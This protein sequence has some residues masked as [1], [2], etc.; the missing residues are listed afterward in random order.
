M[1]TLDVLQPDPKAGPLGS[2]KP[3]RCA[4]DGCKEDGRWKGYCLKHYTLASRQEQTQRKE[5]PMTEQNSAAT[6]EKKPEQTAKKKPIPQEKFEEV[7]NRA[8]T[9]QEAA[10]ELRVSSGAIATRCKTHGIPTPAQ[11][12]GK[13][14]AKKKT[15]PKKKAPATA[16]V[17]LQAKNPPMLP[18][19]MGPVVALE[20]EACALQKIVTALQEL[21]PLAQGRVLAH[22]TAAINS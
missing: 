1:S 15:T 2:Y 11:R 12:N 21:A 18:K 16:P 8:L 14:T 9:N 5:Y 17:E 10:D 20:A 7:I 22:V 19:R 6:E 13:T 3:G 4:V